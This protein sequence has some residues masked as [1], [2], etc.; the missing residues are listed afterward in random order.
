MQQMWVGFFVCFFFFFL[1][2]FF[3]LSQLTNDSVQLSVETVSVCI[4]WW[5][6]NVL[7]MA[8]SSA[9]KLV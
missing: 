8:I 3:F 4:D 6:K 5:F 7:K 9:V 1:V 2:M